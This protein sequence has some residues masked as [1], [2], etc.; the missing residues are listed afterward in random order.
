MPID[1]HTT[2]SHGQTL[3]VF[4]PFDLTGSRLSSRIAK[5]TAA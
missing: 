1:E 3:A 4:A 5:L 2:D